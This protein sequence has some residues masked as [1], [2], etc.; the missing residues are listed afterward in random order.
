VACRIT[1]WYKENKLSN[2]IADVV[3]CSDF[4][5]Q[6]EELTC[7]FVKISKTESVL[8]KR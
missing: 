8:G 5:G 6:D 7:E 2:H 4:D 3:Q 1:D